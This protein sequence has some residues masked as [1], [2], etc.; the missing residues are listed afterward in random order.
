MK[1]TGSTATY[2]VLGN[3]VTHSLS[4]SLHNAWMAEHGIDAVY[5]ALEADP[6][7]IDACLA[8]LAAAGVRG[9]NVTAPFKEDAARNARTRSEMVER[10][11]AAN[12][13]CLTGAGYHSHSTDGAGFVADLDA[14]APD[15]RTLDGP[16][17]LLGAGGAAKS[18]LAALTHATSRQVH[19]VNRSPERAAAT[20]QLAHDGRVKLWGWDQLPAAMAGASLV[21]NATT[22]GMKNI[23]PLELDLA[24]T[25]PDCWVYDTV[26]VPRETALLASAREAKRRSLDGLGM[27][28][29]QGALSFEHWFAIKPDIV[30]ALK[31]L[32][33]GLA[34]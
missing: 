20:A 1:I 14:R 27:L 17:V 6:A 15:W 26:Y 21:V 4:P 18:V 3:P 13:L 24:A 29:G 5:V 2:G 25:S 16:I 34:S 22:R 19:L 11:G 28:V 32:E 7:R 8:G 12:C 33:A 31:R 9:L 23:N 10:L 30:T